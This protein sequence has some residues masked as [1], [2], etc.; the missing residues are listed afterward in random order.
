MQ[1]VAPMIAL[2]TP[3]FSLI[4]DPLRVSEAALSEL[5][6]EAR[7]LQ[8]PGRDIREKLERL[9]AALFTGQIVELPVKHHFSR[10]VYAREL[11]IPKGTVLVGKIH[12][13]SQVNIVSR[14]EISVLTEDGIKR[15]KAGSHIV[16][17]PGVKRAGYAHEDTVWTTI[18]GTYETNLEKLEQELIAASFEDYDT[19]CAALA[20]EG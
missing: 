11:F 18:H 5:A 19:F 1:I 6:D 7:A 12:K 8:V 13:F 10:G 3:V 4:V 9:E 2:P 17:G 15:V 14:G 16:A 20:L